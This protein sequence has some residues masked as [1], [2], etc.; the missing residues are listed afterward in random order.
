MRY[1]SLRPSALA[2]SAF[3][4]AG[5]AGDTTTEP[6]SA[7]QPPA[8][9]PELAV[10]SNSW[11]TRAN[12]PSNRTSLAT[13]IVTNTA[14]QSIVYAIGGLNSSRV[15][16]NT[17]TAYN[18]AT[19][20]WTFRHTLPVRL[21]G[22]NGAGVINGKIYV[23]GGYSDYNG[24]FPTTA[25]YMYNPATNTWTR[26]RDIPVVTGGVNADRYAAGNG[27]TGVIDGKLYVVSGCFQA[28]D[29]WGYYET[30]NP[31]FF[32]YNPATD[33]WV[34]LPSPFAVPAAGP[35]IGGVIA[36]KFYVMAGSPYTHDAY[37]AVYDP[38]TNQWTPKNP[39]GLSRPG[40]G[41]AVLGG[42]LYVIGGTRYN[43]ARDGMETLD[44]TIVYD[45]AT[46]VWTRRASMPSARTS[47]AASKVLLNGKARIEV[48]GGIAPGNNIQYVP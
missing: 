35:S 30:C 7:A 13:A 9:V 24:D 36:G 10:A 48:V 20:T 25:L 47:I 11:I 41:S 3:W 39:L 17:V 31:L 33:R 5:C 26:K 40:A 2:L 15:P 27:V 43:A 45:P 8:P 16:V 46:N 4:L 21:A 44:I 6:T 37:F 42:Q 1:D 14:G 32:R 34:R 12:M 38:V 19:N 18:V 29:P 22:S 28:Q 23:S